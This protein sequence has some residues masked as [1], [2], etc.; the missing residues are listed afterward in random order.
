MCSIGIICDR[1]IHYVACVT[2]MLCVWGR[3]VF[4]CSIIGTTTYHPV[5]RNLIDVWR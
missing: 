2:L 5:E 1:V 3:G 4:V